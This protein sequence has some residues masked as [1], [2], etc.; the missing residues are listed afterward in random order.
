[1]L[2]YYC[3]GLLLHVI[4]YFP[5]LW[6]KNTSWCGGWGGGGGGGGWWIGWWWGWGWGWWWQWWWWLVAAQPPFTMCLRVKF[7]PPDPAALKEEITRWVRLPLALLSEIPSTR[8]RLP[9]E[10]WLYSLRFQA[11]IEVQEARR[12]SLSLVPC[13]PS[14]APCPNPVQVIYINTILWN[15]RAFCE[16]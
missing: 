11:L 12:A 3:T 5:L 15:A 13:A 1:M 14:Q 4:H 9:S 16:I 7:Y 6:Y 10:T 2:L 8:L